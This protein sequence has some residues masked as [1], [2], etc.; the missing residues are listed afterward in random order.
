[1]R[2]LVLGGGGFI[3]KNLCRALVLEGNEVIAVGRSARPATLLPSI[4]WH[5]IDFADSHAVSV[6]TRDCQVVYHVVG[7]SSPQQSNE[8]PSDDLEQSVAASVRFL[9]LTA[10][11]GARIVFVSSGGTIY[12]SPE[13][14]PVAEDALPSPTC[15]YAINKLAVEMYLD[16]FR[17][18]RGLDYC[19]LRVANPFGPEQVTRRQQGV[20]AAFMRAAIAREP[21][22]IWGDG[23]QIRDFIYIDDVCRALVMAGKAPAL[24]ER[25]LNIGSGEG[26]SVLEIIATIE[27]L[28]GVTLYKTFAGPRQVDIPAIVLDIE[29]SFRQLGWKPL[30]Q[31]RE[32]METT[33]NWYMMDAITVVEQR[34]WIED[35]NA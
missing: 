13:K 6:L 35:W 2:T 12:G 10:H 21:V 9:D 15:A 7:N 24:R 11:L 30:L 3:G 1:M 33:F 23:T 18:L 16:L 17:R 26:R 29:A 4:H 14:I 20:I 31:W 34:Q 5:Q 8:N 32:A 25:I 22:T 27:S 28:T 19:V